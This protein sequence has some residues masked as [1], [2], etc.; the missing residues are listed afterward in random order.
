MYKYVGERLVFVRKVDYFNLNPCV[1]FYPLIYYTPALFSIHSIYR[2]FSSFV[3]LIKFFFS[4]RSIVYYKYNIYVLLDKGWIKIIVILSYP[5]LWILLLNAIQ[6]ENI[7]RA[8]KY[9]NDWLL[10]IRE[11]KNTIFKLLDTLLSELN[12]NSILKVFSFIDMVVKE[13]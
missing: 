7:W 13:K 11:N 10:K 4:C 12:D 9:W 8:W 2:D 6:V 3:F 5:L 1:Y